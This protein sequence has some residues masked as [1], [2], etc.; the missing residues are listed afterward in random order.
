MS[1]PQVESPAPTPDDFLTALEDAYHEVKR[2]RRS[3]RMDDS[4]SAGL[5][6]DSLAATELLLALEQ[7]YGIELIGTD[8]VGRTQTVAQLHVVVTELV[9]ARTA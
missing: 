2:M 9:S 6:L 1:S 8:A 3:I 7:R 4:L 5:G